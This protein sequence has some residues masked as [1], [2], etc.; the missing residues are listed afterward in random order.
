[1]PEAGGG[2]WAIK[3]AEQTPAIASDKSQRNFVVILKKNLQSPMGA[4][5]AAKESS[6][7]LCIF[8][9]VRGKDV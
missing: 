6:R 1:M 4:D 8:L 5:Q 3:V 9:A 7:R 2:G